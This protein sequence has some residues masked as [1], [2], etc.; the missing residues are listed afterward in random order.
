MARKPTSTAETDAEVKQ[1]V[2]HH[3]KLRIDDLKTFEP[4]T[5]NQKKFFDAYKR[6]D[7]FIG[8]FGY[9][10]TGKSTIAA[11]KAFEEV[12]D[13]SN[14]YKQVVVVRS[15]VQVRDQ[16]YLPGTLEEKMEIYEA[17]YKDICHTLFGRPDAWQRLK[18]QNVAKFI[19]TTAIRGI[20]I[21]DS[22]V[23]VDESA[24]CSW[25]ELSAIFARC[26]NRTKIIFC[27]DHFQNDLT[28]NKHDVSGLAKFIDVARSMDEFTEINFTPEDII[29]SDLVRA[30]ILACAKKGLLPS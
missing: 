6:G 18:E 19:S 13:K 27:G 21:S 14:P 11:I 22:I 24:N 28:K 8:L 23:I 12:L 7:M 26:G 5:E 29:R 2:N 20:T 3:L 4:L 1:K 15:A 9:P 16:G 25:S 17:P 10:G 30:F